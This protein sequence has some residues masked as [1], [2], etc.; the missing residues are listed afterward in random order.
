MILKKPYGF[1]IKH[2]KLIHFFLAVVMAFIAFRTY[3]IMGFFDGYSAS[4]GQAFTGNYASIYVPVYLTI[5]ILFVIVLFGVIVWLL[6]LK[7]KKNLLYIILFICYVVFLF[8]FQFMSG[9]LRGLEVT[10]LDIQNIKLYRDISFLFSI[11]QLILTL[12]IASRSVGLNLKTFDFETDLLELEIDKRDTE[13]FE[14]NV[15]VDT[16]KWRSGIRAF[17]R[18]LGYFVKENAYVLKLV[19]VGIVLLSFVVIFFNKQVVNKIYAEGKEF[20]ADQFKMAVY[21]SYETDTD[22]QSINISPDS[23]YVI[24]D[25]SLENLSEKENPIALENMTLYYNNKAYQ[26]E[27]QGYNA[28]RDLGDAIPDHLSK[29]GKGRYIVIFK[30]PNS[31]KDSNPLFRYRTDVVSD[32]EGLL[33]KYKKAK[34]KPQTFGLIRTIKSAKMKEKVK[35]DQSILKNSTVQINSVEFDTRFDY[36][37]KD[38]SGSTCTEYQDYIKASTISNY[39]KTLMK[40]NMKINIDP[41]VAISSHTNL[42][43]YIETF[44]SI[45]YTIGNT[46]KIQEINLINRTPSNYQGNEIFVEV[47]EEIQNASTINLRFIIRDKKYII[48]IK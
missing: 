15:Q 16:D 40:L 20:S 26:A 33:G 45:S 18:N 46:N 12:I 6:Y 38:C 7:K 2:F 9:Q 10:P 36:T 24:V 44:G 34:L 31:E 23:K 27:K 21:N 37:Y 8:Y 42:F 1:L 4:K 28:F 29:N 5:L 30:V 14:V 17:F 11:I 19:G 39:N 25:L 41:T 3:S 32:K 13:Q 35:L 47:L 43:Y 48:K 22:Y